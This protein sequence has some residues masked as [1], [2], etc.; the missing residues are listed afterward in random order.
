MSA[1]KKLVRATEWIQRKFSSRGLILMYHRVANQDVDPWAM[2]VSPEHLGEQLEVLQKETHPVSLGQLVQSHR[3]GK[4]PDRAVAVTFDDGY[5]DNLHSA[6]PLLDRYGIPATVFV[7]SGHIGNEREYWWDELERIILRPATIP[8]TLSLWIQDKTFKWESGEAA[9]YSRNKPERDSCWIIN[10]QENHN[11]RH[12]LYFTLHQLLQ[13]LSEAE[14]RKVMDELFAWAGVSHSKR[15]NYRTLTHTEL[16]N[17]SQGELIEVGAH[18]VTHP[19]LSVLPYSSQQDEIQRGKNILEESI[20]RQIRSFSYPYGNYTMETVAIV[21][22]SGYDCACSVS[23]DSVWRGSDLFQLPR[24][25][26]EDWGGEEF[27]QR[28]LEWI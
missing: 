8:E 28:L 20:G 10:R 9:K 11:L 19:F 3:N 1:F 23:K 25:T 22:K 17:L 5:A 4:I 2:C 21:R 26:I 7:V 15:S 27:R 24:I 18:T 13:P 6:K 12:S 16:L 14:R